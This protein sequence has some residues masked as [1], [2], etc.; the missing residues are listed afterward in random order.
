VPFAP[1]NAKPWGEMPSYYVPQVLGQM[2]VVGRSYGDL[3]AFTR[4]NGCVAFRLEA[5]PA[6]W[7]PMRG[8]LREF[9]HAHVLPARQAAAQGASPEELRAQFAPRH[10]E[11]RAEELKA[12]CRALLRTTVMTRFATPTEAQLQAELARQAAQR[13]P[14]LSG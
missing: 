11:A 8:V 3:F 14:G 4:R 6:T 10:D 7:E 5:A 2:A 9:W 12:S 1:E 13:R